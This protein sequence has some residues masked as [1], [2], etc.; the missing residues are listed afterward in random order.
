[1]AGIGLVPKHCYSLLNEFIH[2]FSLISKLGPQFNVKPTKPS[3][4]F[5]FLTRR[6]GHPPPP[7]LFGITVHFLAC[8]STGHKQF[9]LEESFT[10]KKGV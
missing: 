7:P 6:R 9:C 3:Y 1:M 4:P 5:A 2:L 8:L 10:H